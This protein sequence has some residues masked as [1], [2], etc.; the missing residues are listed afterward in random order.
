MTSSETPAT[1]NTV[2]KEAEDDEEVMNQTEQKFYRSGVGKL[3]HLMRWSRPDIYNAVRDLSR[4]GGKCTK[5]HIKAMKRCMKYC[6]ET[7]H[8][9]WKLCP[10]RKWDGKDKNFQFRVHGKS[11]SDYACDPNIS[12]MISSV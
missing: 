5:A 11:D 10:E 7:K 9:G 6:V 3:L 4:H 8:M 1:A 12:I 2:L